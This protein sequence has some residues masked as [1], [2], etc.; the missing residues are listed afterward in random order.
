MILV[1]PL[2][3]LVHRYFDN[4]DRPG[5]AVGAVNAQD[6]VD[7]ITRYLADHGVPVGF[8]DGST[9]TERAT[10]ADSIG[11]V[12]TMAISLPL[13]VQHRDGISRVYCTGPDCVWSWPLEPAETHLNGMSITSAV[14]HVLH[15]HTIPH[16]DTAT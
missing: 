15:R 14:A 5:A 12:P 4:P 6:L 7:H 13:I 8:A 9:L 1:E 3:E 16:A 2:E 11:T 10:C